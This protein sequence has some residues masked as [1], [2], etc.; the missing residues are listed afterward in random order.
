M[1]AKTDLIKSLQNSGVELATSTLKRKSMAELETIWSALQDRDRAAND[2]KV[3][4]LTNRET[5]C[6]G[7]ENGECDNCGAYECC[8]ETDDFP[9]EDLV[10]EEPASDR[11]EKDYNLTG[12]LVDWMLNLA[13]QGKTPREVAADLAQEGKSDGQSKPVKDRDGIK[14]AYAMVREV[15]KVVTAAGHQKDPENLKAA[16]LALAEIAGK[17][18]ERI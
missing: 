17:A 2:G 12:E 16:F 18:A 4:D 15:Q 5:D 7:C 3:E 10:A 6:G 11:V 8:A 9:T 14:E 1:T 13:E